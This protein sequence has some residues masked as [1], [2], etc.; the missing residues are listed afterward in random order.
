[1]LDDVLTLRHD[2]NVRWIQV[3]LPTVHVTNQRVAPMPK[4]MRLC[5]EH[6]WQRWRTT[7]SLVRLADNA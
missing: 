5:G 6:I 7:N 4:R 1:M 2:G 3:A